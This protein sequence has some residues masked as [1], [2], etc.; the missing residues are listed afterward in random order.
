MNAAIET[1]IRDCPQCAEFQNKA[2]RTTPN[3]TD[4]RLALHRG[5][6]GHIRILEQQLSAACGL[7]FEVHRSQ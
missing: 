2:S 3:N 6:C 1:A 4:P 7:S 5:R